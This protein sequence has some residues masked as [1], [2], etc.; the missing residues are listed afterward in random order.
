M[1]PMPSVTP[2]STERPFPR[3]QVV[4]CQYDFNFHL[5]YVNPAFARMLGYS[6]EERVG[7]PLKRI[8]HPGIPQ[9]LLDDIRATTGRG[10]PW[11]GMAKTLRRDGGDAP[12]DARPWYV[13]AGFGDERSAVA[14]GVRPEAT[15]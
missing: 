4:V 12:D 9:A 5:T 1:Q 13:R 10:Q 11:R 7:Q 6:R 2:M 14:A 15:A 3:G 8:A